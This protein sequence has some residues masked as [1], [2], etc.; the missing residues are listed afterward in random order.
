LG[1]SQSEK[2]GQSKSEKKKP[3]RNRRWIAL[4]ITVIILWALVFGVTLR[5]WFLGT[6]ALVDRLD[7]SL[8]TYPILA[9]NLIFVTATFI[10]FFTYF[11]GYRRAVREQ[12]QAIEIW[13]VMRKAYPNGPIYGSAPFQHN[14]GLRSGPLCSIII[15][16]RDEEQ[17]IR[18]T[19]RACLGQSY[20][21]IEVLVICH[22]CSDRT[23]AEASNIG[24][25]RVRPIELNTKEAGKGIA[26]NHG[27]ELS[28]GD[29][30]LILDGDGRLTENFIQDALPLF[31]ARNY[32][33]VQGRYVPSNREYN[34]I[35]RMLSLEGD[36]WSTPF[37][38]SRGVRTKRVGL[39]G[40][41]YI[42]RKDALL[43]VGGFKNHLVDDYELTYRLLRRK[44]RVAYA[45]LCINFDE[46]P[47][48]L[49]I[50]LKQRARWVKGFLSLM[51][52]RV[53]ER[54]DLAG[55]LFWLNPLTAFTSFALLVLAGF[56]TL[57]YMAFMYYPFQYSY[58]PLL[59]WIGLTLGTFAIYTAALVMQ[60]GKSGFKYA[61]WLP[62][63]LPFANY[64]MVVALK[65]FF[66]KSWAETKTVHG[67]ISTNVHKSQKTIL[68]EK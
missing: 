1:K 51:R 28:K 7:I 30:I 36:L 10:V 41:G 3:S 47:P 4:Y 14:R 27:V 8:F 31:A 58:I 65:A 5:S 66:V 55:H 57:H 22:N 19:I 6:E 18:N 24:D 42:V 40:T 29:Y 13:N 45:P 33:A 38:T 25:D 39:G 64:Y 15:P 12:K 16:A 59:P 56:S 49:D 53:A 54:S 50:M 17:V 9:F 62:I 60:Y 26:L 2:L 44:Y 61:A 67:F 68:K 21:N 43:A 20:T 32:S 52:S 34:F 46:K 35:T 63:Y 37:M 48:T 23:Y 11:G